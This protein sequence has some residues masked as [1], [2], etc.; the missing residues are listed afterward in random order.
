MLLLQHILHAVFD[1]SVVADNHDDV[2]V[3]AVVVVVAELVLTYTVVGVAV[4][5][6][7]TFVVDV[8]V[9]VVWS[10]ALKPIYREYC[11]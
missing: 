2:H 3:N 11:E 4:L 10:V 5:I 1:V 8:D 7:N 9:G 6:T